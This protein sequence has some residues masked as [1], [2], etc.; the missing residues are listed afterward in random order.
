MLK[1]WQCQG[2]KVGEWERVV[3]YTA[4]NFL[5]KNMPVLD[6][7]ISIFFFN[8]MVTNI[9]CEHKAWLYLENDLLIFYACY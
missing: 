6:C 1:N 8:F 3:F 4:K 2:K 7:I 9:S 5:N